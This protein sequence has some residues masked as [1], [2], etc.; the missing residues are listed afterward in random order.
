VTPTPAQL[1]EYLGEYRSDEVQTAY[2]IV[3]E[4]GK[5]F[6]RHENEFKD[7]PKSPLEPTTSDT[8]SVQGINIHFVRDSRNQMS[9]F[10]LNA[11]RVKN[12]RFVKT[13]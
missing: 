3:L 13:G 12:I 11:G 1:S 8:F 5:L 7:Y 10:I 6:M 4:N 9:A 2:R